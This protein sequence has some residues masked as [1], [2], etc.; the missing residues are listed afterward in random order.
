[1]DRET[2]SG[3]GWWGI[4]IVIFLLFIVCGNG[5]GGGLWGRGNCG[6]FGFPFGGSI[7]EGFGFQNYKATCDA[8]K[9]EI[10]NSATTQYKVEQQGAAT[11]EAIAADGSATRA[12]IDFYAYQ[13]LRD[14]LAESQRQ[15]MMLQNQIYSDAK[16]NALSQQLERMDYQMIKQPRLAG[17]TTACPPGAVINPGC[18]CGSCGNGFVA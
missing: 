17:L 3:I 1:M 6:G 5:F 8:E 13:D 7:G 12:K 9:A 2:S 10:V 16:F 11:R 14:K 18:G 4:V 15:N